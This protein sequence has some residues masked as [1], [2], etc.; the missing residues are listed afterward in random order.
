[1]EQSGKNEQIIVSVQNKRHKCIFWLLIAIIIALFVLVGILIY[2]KC[3]GPIV[4]D[5]SSSPS[6]DMPDISEV[7][8]TY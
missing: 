6:F 5:I 1:M 3:H 2:K 7:F 8:M 4:L